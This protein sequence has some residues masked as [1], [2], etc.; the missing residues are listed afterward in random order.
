MTEVT[1]FLKFKF[2]METTISKLHANVT[3]TNNIWAEN[4]QRTL[5]QDD[6]ESTCNGYYVS[7]ENGS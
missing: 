7:T 1:Y 5:T 6:T 2:V 3:I 4:V